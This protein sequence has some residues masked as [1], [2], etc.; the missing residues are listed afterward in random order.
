MNNNE[1]VRQLETKVINFMNE[2]I[3]ENNCD[4]NTQ[5]PTELEDYNDDDSDDGGGRVMEMKRRIFWIEKEFGKKYENELTQYEFAILVKE[6]LDYWKYW[7]DY[8]EPI[9]LN[10]MLNNAIMLNRY[11]ISLVLDHRVIWERRES[12]N[13]LK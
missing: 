10:D 1:T 11:A 8:A 3:Y 9:K 12:V 2:F 4:L 6:T 5:Y 13:I 7:Y